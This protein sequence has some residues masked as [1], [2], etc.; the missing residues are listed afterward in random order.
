MTDAEVDT[1]LAVLERSTL[2]LE[3]RVLMLM[4]EFLLRFSLLSVYKLDERR[5]LFW[6]Y[7]KVLWELLANENLPSFRPVSSWVTMMKAGLLGKAG[8]V[9]CLVGHKN[10]I[11]EKLMKWLQIVSFR[12]VGLNLIITTRTDY[13]RTIKIFPDFGHFWG[14]LVDKTKSGKFQF[15]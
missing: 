6:S 13:C 10:Q 12:V 9:R 1:E 2:K 11:F 5:I 8:W 7:G 14:L 3:M 15:F 4:L